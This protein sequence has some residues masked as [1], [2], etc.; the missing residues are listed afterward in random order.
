L[1]TGID[2]L[3]ESKRWPTIGH[4]SGLLDRTGEIK[5]R[6][7]ERASWWLT[8]PMVRIM[9]RTAPNDRMP[10]DPGYGGEE[11]HTQV[12]FADW[13]SRNPTPHDETV[14]A[15]S[16]CEEVELFLNDKSLGAQKINADASPRIWKIS[17]APGTLKA[18]AKNG[19]KIVANDELRTAGKAAKIILS[20]ETK[21][22][23][24]TWDDVAVVRATI[25]DA[26]GIEIPRANDLIAFKVSGPGV[27]A[28]VDNGDNAS[29]ELFQT[30]SRHAFQG[31]CVAFVKATAASGKITLSATAAGLDAG[32]ITLKASPELSR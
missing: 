4:A 2:Y 31:E 14:E 24:P 1:W 6:A 30:D 7:F 9:R 3:G 21:K 16:N 18:V 25:V 23:S 10:T 29:H 17:F 27:I 8:G 28:A 13:T 32:S 19:G 15:Y 20:T 12:E 5:P 22:L 11:L 26:N